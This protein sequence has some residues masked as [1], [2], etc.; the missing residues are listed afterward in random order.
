MPHGTGRYFRVSRRG[1]CA[2]SGAPG[3]HHQH[4]HRRVVRARSPTLRSSSASPGSTASPVTASPSTGS[5][6]TPCRRVR[7]CAGAAV[8][9]RDSR[10]RTV[11]PPRLR[12]RVCLGASHR[13]RTLASRKRDTPRFSL[14]RPTQGRASRRRGRAL[15]RRA[16]RLHARACDDDD[17]HGDGDRAPTSAMA[18]AVRQFTSPPMNCAPMC[19]LGVSAVADSDERRDT[20]PDHGV[21]VQIAVEP[22]VAVAALARRPFARPGSLCP[23]ARRRRRPL[24]R[25]AHRRRAP[26]RDDDHRDDDGAPVSAPRGIPCST[27][28]PASTIAVSAPRT[29][30]SPHHRLGVQRRLHPPQTSR[31]P[32]GR[33]PY[34]CR[35]AKG[36][37][38]TASTSNLCPARR[39]RA[40]VL[41]PDAAGCRLKSGTDMNRY[42]QLVACQM[43]QNLHGVTLL[44]CREH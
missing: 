36:L 14:R 8:G 17:D 24:H 15:L 6:D 30:C 31:Q 19:T 11:P 35:D 41:T 33:S 25:S 26:S 44:T 16:H 22:I 7:G 28:G 23:A 27:V 39:F 1:S 4:P 38:L 18:H 29:I 32:C 20:S 13:R 43:P 9:E 34:S 40:L 5:R 12:R 2:Q 10:P 3:R 42:Q 21:A 37:A